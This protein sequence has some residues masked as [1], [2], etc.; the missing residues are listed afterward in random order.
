MSNT[1]KNVLFHVFIGELRRQELFSWLRILL[2]GRH[3]LLIHSA[4]SQD[5]NLFG[6]SA[7]EKGACW[8]AAVLCANH[9]VAEL[10]PLFLWSALWEA[11]KGSS[12]WS[13]LCF[14]WSLGVCPKG[15]CVGGTIL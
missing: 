5:A 9:C 2:A 1:V 6:P 14:G 15:S 11:T 10:Y 7:Q 13:L 4:L 3:L 8:V 12:A